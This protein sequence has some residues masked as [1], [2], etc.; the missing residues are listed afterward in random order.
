MCWLVHKK[1]GKVIPE[2]YI[3]QA[4]KHNKDGFGISYMEDEELQVYK[5]LDLAEFKEKLGTLDDKEVVVH[6]RAASIGGVSV[7]NIH[8]FKTSTGVMFHNGT[9]SSFR[10]KTDKCPTTGCLDS[11]TKALADLISACNYTTISDIVPL[12]Q[13]IITKTSNKL[14]FHENDG[15]VII[16]NKDLG[17][18]EDGIWYSN[19]YHIEPVYNNSWYNEITTDKVFVYGTLKEG[20]SN[21]GLLKD[22]EF[23]CKAKTFSKY[24]MIGKDRI[25]PY[26]LGKDYEF[27]DIKKEAHQIIGEVY[28]VDAE[29]LA[30]LDRL[31]GVPSH[32]NKEIAYV[33]AIE[34]GKAETTYIYVKTTVAESMFEEEMLSEWLPNDDA[35]SSYG[36]SDDDITNFFKAYKKKVE[37]T[38]FFTEEQLRQL[39]NDRLEEIYDEY[40]ELYYGAVQPSYMTP[41][42]QA[43]FIEAITELAVDI[44]EEYSQL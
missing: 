41:R 2:G 40:C 32:Y 16:M 39:N 10:G 12:L 14:V 22:A 27:R 11:D 23:V 20:L 1:P 7:A 5:T 42:T 19:D 35:D 15:S 31:E 18:E 3:D 38:K 33:R 37:A 25:F 36:T 34:T 24:Y 21:H 4:V 13:H 28:K 44:R 6:L 9:I 8:P 29:T 17:E 26:V 43:K 30:K